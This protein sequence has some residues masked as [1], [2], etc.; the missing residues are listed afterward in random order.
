MSVCEWRECGRVLV[1]CAQVRVAEYFQER[2]PARIV[3]V[4]GEGLDI[5]FME[6]F[7]EEEDVVRC[8]AVGDQICACEAWMW[9]TYEGMEDALGGASEEGKSFHDLRIEIQVFFY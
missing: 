5:L 1:V 3:C 9:V 2:E 4:R 8:Q 7:G 6:Q